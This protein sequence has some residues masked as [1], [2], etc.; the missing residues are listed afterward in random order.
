MVA[1]SIWVQV[2]LPHAED[3]PWTAFLPGAIVL[4]VG[5][6]LLRLV[7]QVYFAGRLDRVDDLYGALGL[8][9]VFMAWLYLIARLIVASFAVS[10][11]RWRSAETEAAEADAG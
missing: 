8:A 3:A 9:A 7:T 2:I 4:A 10:A 1:L 6:D 5:A 11:T